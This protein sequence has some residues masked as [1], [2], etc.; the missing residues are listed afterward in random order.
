M[1]PP[2]DVQKTSQKMWSPL[3]HFPK[4]VGF[5]KELNF[6]KLII[7]SNLAS[8]G[9]RLRGDTSFGTSFGKPRTICRVSADYRK[10]SYSSLGRLLEN[11]MHFAGFQRITAHHRAPDHPPNADQEHKTNN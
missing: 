3:R 7:L 5:Y 8:F 6:K 9:K 1:A 11:F 10:S 2:A 4:D